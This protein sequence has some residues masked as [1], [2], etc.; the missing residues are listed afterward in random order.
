M[1][2]LGGGGVERVAGR[3]VCAVGSTVKTQVIKPSAPRP[4]IPCFGM[5]AE[6]VGERRSP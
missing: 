3:V 5:G 2:T 4:R 1:K 6:D